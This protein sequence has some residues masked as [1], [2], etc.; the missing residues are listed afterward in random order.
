[1]NNPMHSKSWLEKKWA[2]SSFFTI[3]YLVLLGKPDH[4]CYPLY[5]L[6]ICSPIPTPPLSWVSE[7]LNVCSKVLL[8][9]FPDFDW[10]NSHF[11]LFRYSSRVLLIIQLFHYYMYYKIAPHLCLA[12]YILCRQKSGR[13]HIAIN[14]AQ[15]HSEVLNTKNLS[16]I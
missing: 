15:T 11:I 4:S 7:L 10:V 3:Y 5:A 14:T 9:L 1:M 12:E 2:T 8:L 13:M 6:W 16:K